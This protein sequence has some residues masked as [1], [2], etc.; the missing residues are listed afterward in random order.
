MKIYNYFVIMME[1]SKTQY[2]NVLTQN[3][4]IKKI[5][6]LKIKLQDRIKNMSERERE[7]IINFH[8][9][10]WEGIANL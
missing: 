3:R 9:R 7:R 8:E 2:Q 6:K 5:H 4:V 10:M 1:N